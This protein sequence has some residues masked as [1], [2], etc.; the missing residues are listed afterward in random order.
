MRASFSWPKPGPPSSRSRK[1]AHRPLS[2]T[3]CFRG[4]TS[5]LALGLRDQA[6]PGKTRSSGSISLRQNCSTQS[7]CSWNSGSVEKSHATVSP[8]RSFALTRE[9]LEAAHCQRHV[10]VLE[11]RGVVAR[12]ARPPLGQCRVDGAEENGD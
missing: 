5:A 7:S 11:K 12:R 1:S 3:C 4:S 2:L 9:L 10:G 6:A 8:H